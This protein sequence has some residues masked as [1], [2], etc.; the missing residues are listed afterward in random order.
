MITDGNRSCSFHTTCN[1]LNE[2]KSFHTTPSWT[3]R[4]YGFEPIRFIM[5]QQGPECLTTSETGMAAQSESPYDEWF[6]AFK[7]Y[8]ESCHFLAVRD[9]ENHMS[10]I[11]FHPRSYWSCNSLWIEGIYPKWL[12]IMGNKHAYSTLQWLQPYSSLSSILS[13]LIWLINTSN[14]NTNK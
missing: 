12:Q 13:G 3:L 1:E 9:Y 14:N 5:I 6:S 7:L 11:K 4:Y 10:S 2:Q 8:T